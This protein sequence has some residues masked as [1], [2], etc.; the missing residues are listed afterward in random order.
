RP[1]RSFETAI[2]RATLPC[3]FEP[4]IFNGGTSRQARPDNSKQTHTGSR[5]MS[6]RAISRSIASTALIVVLGMAL[7]ANRAWASGE[8]VLLNFTGG[9]DGSQPVAGLTPDGAGNYYG[10]TFY[11]G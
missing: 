9:G 7:S 2:L 8:K 5:V 10:V 3:L 4:N 6:T 1:P 11:G